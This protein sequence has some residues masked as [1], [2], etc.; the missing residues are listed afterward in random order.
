MNDLA[1]ITPYEAILYE[2]HALGVRV[3]STEYPTETDVQQF[4]SM[5]D[6]LQAAAR[7][8]LLKSYNSS[9]ES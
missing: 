6:V 5:L 3:F 8:H 4:L 7:D 2:A 9:A 1:H